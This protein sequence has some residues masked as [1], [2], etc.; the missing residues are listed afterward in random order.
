MAERT[1]VGFSRV[2]CRHVSHFAA[3][4]IDDRSGAVEP[5]KIAMST[6]AMKV[7]L[8]R[9]RRKIGTMMSDESAKNERSAKFFRHK[10]SSNV[11]DTD[12]GGVKV[13]VQRLTDSPV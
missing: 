12:R 9:R 4:K 6:V 5:M 11:P 2:D 7:V 8:P 10:G 3:A 13:V 1:M